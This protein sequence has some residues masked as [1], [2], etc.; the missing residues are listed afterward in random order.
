MKR[1][2]RP[3]TAVVEVKFKVPKGMSAAKAREF[4]KNNL[5]T[6][7]YTSCWEEDVIGAGKVKLT[8]GKALIIPSARPE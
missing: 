2:K 3:N 8:V 4:I 6:E 7:I 5:E 1:K